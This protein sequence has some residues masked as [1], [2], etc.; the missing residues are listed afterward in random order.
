MCVWCKIIDVKQLFL[1]SSADLVVH[2][3]V[4]QLDLSLGKK[5]AFIDTAAEVEPGGK[6]APWLNEDRKSLVRAGF[7]VFDYTLTN[8]TSKQIEQDLSSADIL[9]M[10]GGNTFYL[11]EKAQQSGFNQL[12]TKLVDQL[13]KI[14]IGSSAGSIIA[15]PDIY[16]SYRI[17]NIDKAPLLKGYQGFN[18]VNFC[19]MPHWGSQDFKELYLNS[20]LAHAYKDDQVPLLLL[21]DHQYVR[22]QD[23]LMKIVTVS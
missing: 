13:G 3:I 23:D 9:F 18:L 17:D 15:G 11:L 16:P 5:L 19:V 14:Y 7:E 10:S 22:I 2:D 4:K 6:L 12:V 21:T 1:T 8:K 20:R